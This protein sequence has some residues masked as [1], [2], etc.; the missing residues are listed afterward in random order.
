V[1]ITTLPGTNI[2]AIQVEV[3]ALTPEQVVELIGSGHK[4]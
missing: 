4:N 1:V 3:C 2:P